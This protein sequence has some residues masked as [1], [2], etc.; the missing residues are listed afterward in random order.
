MPTPGLEIT[1][2]AAVILPNAAKLVMPGTLG[3][4]LEFLHLLTDGVDT[5]LR[6]WAEGKPSAISIGSPTAASGYLSLRSGTSYLQT[7]VIDVAGD[8]TMLVVGRDTGDKSADSARFCYVGSNNLL[9]ILTSSSS[10][11]RL[12]MRATQDGG[13]T[14]TS[15]ASLVANPNGWACLIGTAFQTGVSSSTADD[16]T[17][18]D[19]GA[20]TSGTA[21][22]NTPYA[23]APTGAAFTIGH[24]GANQTGPGD[25]A[26]AAAW[27]R[28]LS[29]SERTQAYAWAKALVATK[30]LSI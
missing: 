24:W 4:D 13:A 30:G 3:S 27:S 1:T 20:G 18:Y 2:G 25:I 7:G 19:M 12:T 21:N 15:T 16:P 23:R 14:G 11:T 26:L 17:L 10:Q 29:V 6:N 28:V 22:Y 5:A 9:G 8:V